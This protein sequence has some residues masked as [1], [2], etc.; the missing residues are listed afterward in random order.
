MVELTTAVNEPIKQPT[1]ALANE[2]IIAAQVFVT[3]SS[4]WFVCMAKAQFLLVCFYSSSSSAGNFKHKL[5][6]FL[7]SDILVY[8]KRVYVVVFLAIHEA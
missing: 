8:S 1:G 3:N 6:Y 4:C 7:V 2:D 5:F